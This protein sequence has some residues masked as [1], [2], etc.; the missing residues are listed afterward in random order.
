MNFKSSKK[1]IIISYLIGFIITFF[2]ALAGLMCPP[3]CTAINYLKSS[4]ILILYSIP[5]ALIPA[6]LIFLIYSLLQKK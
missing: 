5:I 6:L 1:K 3:R 2:Y 4:P